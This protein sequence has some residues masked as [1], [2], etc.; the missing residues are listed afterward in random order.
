[1]KVI[2]II[3]NRR[4]CSSEWID[5]CVKKKYIT[6]WF[7][8][9][10]KFLVFHSVIIYLNKSYNKNVNQMEFFY[11]LNIHKKKLYLNNVNF[12][13]KN[14]DMICFVKSVNEEIYFFVFFIQIFY[15]FKFI[16][17]IHD[18]VRTRK[19]NFQ[20]YPGNASNVFVYSF[21]RI[22]YVSMKLRCKNYF[23]S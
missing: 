9:L 14:P 8:A 12:C 17:F 22:N 15:L 20:A 23:L 7:C 18:F 19:V 3:D 5:L 2:F 21:P 11:Q 13:G 4:S 1:M 6:L 16:I 10:V